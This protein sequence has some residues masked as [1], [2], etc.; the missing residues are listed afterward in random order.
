MAAD[1]SSSAAA[2]NAVVGAAAFALAVL[3][4]KPMLSIF[5]TAATNISGP[6][7]KYDISPVLPP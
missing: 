7:I 3:I 5:A 4:A 1:T 2:T 6:V